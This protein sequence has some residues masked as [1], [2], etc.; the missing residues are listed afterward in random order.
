MRIRGPALQVDRDPRVTR[1]GSFLRR[2]SIDELP[3]LWN[4]LYG[5]MSLVGPRPAPPVEVAS[6]EPW[7]RARLAVRPGITGLAQV[8][9]RSYREF[10]EKASLDLEYIVRWSPRLDFEILLRTVPVVVRLT[11]R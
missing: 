8:R 7:H 1:I 3:Q 9:A 2:S 6:Y 4:V 11:G 5:D 10:D